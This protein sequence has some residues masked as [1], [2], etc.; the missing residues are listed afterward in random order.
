MAGERPANILSLYRQCLRSMQRI[1]DVEHRA[2]YGTYV[3][4]GFRSKR[5]LLPN[6]R[7]AL[8]AIRDARVQL[9]R[10]DY[11]HS[12]RVM[13][14]KQQEGHREEQKYRQVGVNSQSIAEG[15]SAAA[16]FAQHETFGQSSEDRIQRGKLS[17]V[18]EWLRVSVPQLHPHDISTYAGCLV[19]DGFDTV[20]M[21]QEELTEQDLDELVEKKAHR[22]AIAKALRGDNTF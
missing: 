1:P 13:K 5:D 14:E 2:T 8:Q 4:D 20:A 3:T 16:S 21:L 19:R 10:M 6:S 11:Y 18:L 12:I 17:I 9:E 15:G 22:R 7:Q